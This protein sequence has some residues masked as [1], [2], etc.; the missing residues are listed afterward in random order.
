MKFQRF[1]EWFDVLAYGG[2]WEIYLIGMCWFKGLFS[3]FAFHM[4]CLFYFGFDASLVTLQSLQDHFILTLR[5]ST[6]LESSCP[7]DCVVLSI[8][9]APA[10]AQNLGHGHPLVLKPSLQVLKRPG[11]RL[12]CWVF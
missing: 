3:A 12:P 5:S 8:R 7:I 10:D 1:F 4:L 11:Y 9:A 6:D 2:L